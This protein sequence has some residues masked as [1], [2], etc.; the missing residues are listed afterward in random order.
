MDEYIKAIKQV[1]KNNKGGTIPILKCVEHSNGTLKATDLTVMVEVE[2]PAIEDGIWKAEALDYG[3]RRDTEETEWGVD[4]FPT[5]PTQNVVQEI[6]LTGEDMA[7]IIR[8][9]DFTSKDMTRPVLTAVVL[10]D[11]K[12]YGADG[13]R[14]YRNKLNHAPAQTVALPA[15]AVKILKTV[16]ANRKDWTLTIYDDSEIMLQ[17]CEFK[18]HSVLITNMPPEYD[19]ITGDGSY[20]YT[21]TV[22]L[23]QIANK[24]DRCLLIEVKNRVIYVSNRNGEERIRLNGMVVNNT[25]TIGNPDHKEVI[26]P[27]ISENE[28]IDLA[29][30][31]QYRGTI[32]LRF[33]KDR[34]KKHVYV[35]E[36]F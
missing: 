18:L 30:L 13:Y 11:G 32:E 15:E 24:K 27:L 28:L 20:D 21:V 5:I 34:N 25:G 4:E 12:V 7:K 10:K 17:S 36:I 26:M 35:N 23:K 9:G 19:A 33:S 22:D 31:K 1:L 29:M 2:T 8:A 16:K 6:E 14:L 3:F